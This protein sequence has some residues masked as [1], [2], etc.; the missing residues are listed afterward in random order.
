MGGVVGMFWWCGVSLDFC[1]D[2]GAGFVFF[3]VVGVSLC[4][5]G[6]RV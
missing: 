4:G 5:L 6:F 1:S 2:F 3:R